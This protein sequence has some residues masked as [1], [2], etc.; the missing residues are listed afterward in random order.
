MMI[1]RLLWYDLKDLSG[2]AIVAQFDCL[3]LRHKAAA[4][5][6]VTAIRKAASNHSSH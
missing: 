6:K 1:L 2:E 3:S 4:H 5:C